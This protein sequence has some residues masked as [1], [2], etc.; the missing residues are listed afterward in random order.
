MFF[1]QYSISKNYL[2]LC[3]CS[4]NKTR[5]TIERNNMTVH[6]VSPITK[7]S[8]VVNKVKDIILEKLDRKVTMVCY[9]YESIL[10]RFPVNNLEQIV[11]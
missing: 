5:I 3:K 1:M 9:T 6:Y 8:S 11:E 10:V 7:K 2:C 4:R